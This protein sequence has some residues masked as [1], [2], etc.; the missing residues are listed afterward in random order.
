MHIAAKPDNEASRLAALYEL[1]ILDTPPE[2]RFDKIAQFAASE[3]DMP[4]VLITL[5]DVERQWFK[6]RVGT[7]VCETGRDL[8]FCSHA[9]LSDATM[10]VEDAL[11]DPR[12]ADNPLVTGAP[13]IRFYAGAP[14]ALPSG[15]RLGTLCLID[16]RPRTLDALDLGIL[17]TLRDLAVMELAR[18]EEKH[19]A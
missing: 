19:D 13:H 15:L 6:A 11:Q 18:A 7:D 17:G 4:I 5:L 8:S 3:F 12:F 2:E 14:L 16:R 9:I 1:L 10:V